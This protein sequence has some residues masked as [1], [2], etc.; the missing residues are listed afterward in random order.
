MEETAPDSF[1]LGEVWE[2][3]T[4]KVAY[5]QRRRYLLGHELPTCE[6]GM[7]TISGKHWKPSGKTTRRRHS[8]P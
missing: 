5:S 6:A 1:L 7:P 3:A 4:T 2:D 8:S